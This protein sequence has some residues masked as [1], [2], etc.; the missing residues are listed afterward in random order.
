M[1]VLSFMPTPGVQICSKMSR[2]NHPLVL[3]E[4]SEGKLG[5]RY[6]HLPLP[7]SMQATIPR[8]RSYYLDMGI[9]SFCGS[10]PEA[11]DIYKSCLLGR[12]S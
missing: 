11:G 5:R 12:G 10:Q 9:R 7:L 4:S 2:G 8:I 6:M 1:V 3:L